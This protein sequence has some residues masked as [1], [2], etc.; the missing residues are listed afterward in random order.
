MRPRS[1]EEKKPKTKQRKTIPTDQTQLAGRTDRKNQRTTRNLTARSHNGK[2]AY[3][4]QLHH[5]QATRQQKQELPR[6]ED[7]A[8]ALLPNVPHDVND[9]LIEILSFFFV[10]RLGGLNPPGTRVPVVR[11][12]DLLKDV[13]VVVVK[14]FIPHLAGK[15]ASKKK[16]CPGLMRINAK[17]TSKSVRPSPDG[18]F[19][20]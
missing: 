17:G 10:N 5:G 3:G 7:T 4:Y 11:R 1:K 15:G 9:H 2:Q 12:L 13:E 16:V 6:S 20:W 19:W 14:D 18:E 8:V